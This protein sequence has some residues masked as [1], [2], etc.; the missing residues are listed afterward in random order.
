[1][2]IFLAEQIAIVRKQ[3]DL[4]AGQDFHWYSVKTD[5]VLLKTQHF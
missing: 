3:G 2:K 5:A 1:L 4:W